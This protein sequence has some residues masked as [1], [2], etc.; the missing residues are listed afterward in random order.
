MAKLIYSM[1]VSLD[2]FI[3]TPRHEIDWHVIDEELHRFANDQARETGVLLYGRRLYEVMTAYW[4]T[5]DADPSNPDVIV[6]Y[7]RIWKDTPKVVFSKT[8]EKVDWNSRLVRDDAA[9][10]IRRLKAEPGKDLAIG[11]ANLASTAIRLGLVDEFRP[12]VHPVVIGAGVPYLPVWD[13][14]VRLHLL[15]TRRFGSGVVYLR[16]DRAG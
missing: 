6:E 11:G 16:Y 4:P 7:A 15:E 13:G 9:G 3:E 1:M 5:A 14:R 10:E 8:L 12:F 2:G